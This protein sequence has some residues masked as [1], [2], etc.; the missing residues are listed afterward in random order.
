MRFLARL[1]LFLALS[2]ATWAADWTHTQGTQDSTAGTTSV[3]FGAAVTSGN[4]V[5]GSVLL[6]TGLTLTNVTDD[7]SNAYTIF[8]SHDDGGLYTAAFRSNSFLT[9][10]PTTLTYTTSAAP[11]TFWKVQDEFA[12]PTGSTSL[13]VDGS[14]STF[15]STGT[16]FTSFTTT[17]SDDLVY[18]VANV[19]GTAT[20]GAGFNVAQGDGTARMAEWGIQATAATVTMTTGTNG[21]NFWGPAF[22]I[23]SAVSTVTCPLTQSLMG[24]GC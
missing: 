9:N 22:G 7:K 4:I 2:T 11:S 3:A 24:V 16:S 6:N 15:N 13:S 14:S 1:C 10:G 23:N 8:E 20:H 21:G 18:A 19:S 5:V 17:L 12:P